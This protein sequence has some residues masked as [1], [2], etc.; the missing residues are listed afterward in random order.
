MREI[1]T[2]PVEVSGLVETLSAMRKFEPDLLANLNKQ[3][4][5]G[6]TPIQKKAQGYIP[7]GVMGLRNWM[8]Q[9]KGRKI[10]KNTSA[11]ATIGKFPR[12]NASI[13]RRGIHIHIGKTKKNINGFVTMYRITNDSRA[14]SIMELAGRVHPDGRPSTHQINFGPVYNRGKKTVHSTKDSNSN[15]PEAA[16]HFVRAMPGRL[17]GSG[18]TRGRLLYRAA[19]E[20]Q[21]RTIAV[22]MKALDKTIAQFHARAATRHAFKSAA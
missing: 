9:T 12:F 20:D 17:T 1:K 15:N 11:F 8:L 13:A 2:M 3:M 22:L 5:A 7:D 10:N 14:G 21:G 19:A 16:A 4:R 6:M 18:S